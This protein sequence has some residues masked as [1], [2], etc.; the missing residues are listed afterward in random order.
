[1]AMMSAFEGKADI[2]K[3]GGNAA[4]DPARTPGACWR[5]RSPPS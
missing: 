1:M 2:W 3:C 5:S 4:N